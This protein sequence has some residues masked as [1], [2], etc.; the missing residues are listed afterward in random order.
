MQVQ[1]TSV[2]ALIGMRIQFNL[3]I[4]VYALHWIKS[5]VSWPVI[6][7]ASIHSESYILILNESFWGV[8]I[9]I[10]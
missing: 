4:S 9:V 6:K 10:P 7:G 3:F 1:L 8:D 2:I 5:L